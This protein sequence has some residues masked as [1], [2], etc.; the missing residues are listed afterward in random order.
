MGKSENYQVKK[1]VKMI[2]SLANREF[3]DFY[4][5]AIRRIVSRAYCNILDQIT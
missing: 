3:K 5:D 2:C 1:S 4:R